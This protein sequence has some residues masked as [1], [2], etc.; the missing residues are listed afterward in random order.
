MT[1]C[2]EAQKDG[3]LGEESRRFHGETCLPRS[4]A[5]THPERGWRASDGIGA[6][7]LCHQIYFVER[8]LWLVGG[9]WMDG[10]SMAASEP[11]RT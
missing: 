7:A 5:W 8:S 4:G 1:G 11:I 6:R 3:G 2:A 9:E 10:V